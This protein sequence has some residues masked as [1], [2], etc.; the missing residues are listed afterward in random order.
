MSRIDVLNSSGTNATAQEHETS[1]P[2]ENSTDNV[3][4]LVLWKEVEMKTMMANKYL[5]LREK[6]KSVKLNKLKFL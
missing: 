3:H 6:N 1:Y 2:L 4:V 5:L